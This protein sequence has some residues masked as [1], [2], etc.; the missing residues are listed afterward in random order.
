MTVNM[1]TPLTPPKLPGPFPP[2]NA[3]TTSPRGW[4]ILLLNRLHYSSVVLS[5]FAFGLFLP[6]IRADL[7]LT[8][9]EIGALQGVWWAA[10]AVFLV[11]FSVLL[12]RFNPNRRVLAGLALI[13]P[14]V[15]SQGLA[16]GFWTLLASRFLTALTQAAM[17]SARP[18]L[19]RRWA[20][21]S[22]YSGVTSV[23]L[24][25]HST[26]MAA[27]LTFSPLIIVAL[28]SWRL[29]YFLQGGLLAA[30]L[31]LWAALTHQPPAPTPDGAASDRQ[32]DGAA[33][34]RQ[35]DGAAPDRQPDGEAPHSPPDGAASD[36]QPDGAAPDR[37]P[38]GA[39]SHRQPD[40]AAPDSPPDGAAPDKPPSSAASHS[41]PDG[42]AS[43]RQP[44]GA[45]P[46]RPPDGAA[47]D[48]QP[49]GAAS[50]TPTDGAAS[51]T[52]P[53]GP[54]PLP[55]QSRA[56][57]IT[58]LVAYPHA[59]LLG[60]VMLCLSASWTTTLTFLPT[61]LEEERGVAI[62]AGSLLFGFLYYAL[63]PGALAG[64]LIFQ[65]LA[66]RRLMTLLPAALNTLFTIAALLSGNATLAALALTGVGLVWIFV[67]ALEILPFEFPNITAREVSAL[68]A[69][70]QTFGA[71]G[72]GGGPALAGAI[73]QATGSLPT[74]A[75]S[76]GVLTGLGIAAAA[77]FP[78]TPGNIATRVSN[79]VV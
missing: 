33:S 50:E 43:H 13:T 55:E 37:Q 48:R 44:D 14:F 26:A 56:R 38:D 47:P 51:E 62:S 66:N 64:T 61:I 25:L 79:P 60:A 12:A 3:M 78:K 36:R 40:G 4:A 24:S 52:P 1:T 34:D 29:A 77:L 17:A 69:L 76:V 74:G 8:Y 35:P 9:L 58:A 7:E 41:P 67:P 28:H 32:P 59:W 21:P 19:L 20:A 16:A 39:A 53:D 2:H 68:A 46:H 63:I 31:L 70:I 23:G 72:F 75:L 10:S 30:Q 45:A 22:Q 27:V 6:F 57:V 49:D 71:V 65:H 11:P 73:A 5:S 42:A 15:F 54:P 18:L